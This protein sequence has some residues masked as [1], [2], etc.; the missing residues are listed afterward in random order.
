MTT[1]RRQL[2]LFGE[3]PPRPRAKRV[4]P[5]AVPDSLTR[6]AGQLPEGL[7]LGTSSWSFP[8]WE[9][10]VYDRKATKAH[11]AREGL[12]AYARHPLL[13]AVGIDR[14]YYAPISREEFAVYTDA[15]PAD[16]RFL[17]KASSDLT[18]PFRR[19]TGR[20][21]AG[22]NELFLAPEY[23]NDH[24]VGPFVEGLGAKAGPL[25]FQFPPQGARI[26]RE[27]T[28][29]AEHLERFLSALPRGPRYAVELRDRALFTEDYVTALRAAHAT[30]CLSMHPR[31]PSIDEQ[32]KLADG[33]EGPLTVRWMLAAGLGY[34][35]AIERYEPFSELVDEDPG[36]RS[37]LADLC[38]VA[39]VAGREVVM[40]AN[41][42]AE[43]CAPGTAFKLAEAV[44][45]RLS[46]PNRATSE[47]DKNDG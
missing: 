1:E 22:V 35:Q 27:P 11:L 43:G 18:T 20:A 9:G 16:F 40:V 39:A 14:T 5:A 45:R 2:N 37:A 33:G 31:M 28:R 34:E 19:G 25:V 24:V 30:H 29:F 38:A 3:P 10:L 4:G 21:P 36:Q 17:V 41:N 7:Y 46:S 26:T 13:R 6:L 47:D 44:A 8:G 32:A 12:E 15:V 23:A 42:K